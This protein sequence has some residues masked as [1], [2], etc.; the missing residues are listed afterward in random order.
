MRTSRNLPELGRIESTSTPPFEVVLTYQDFHCGLRAKEFF[1]RLV[2]DH[3]SLFRF[4][5]HLWRFD[6]L[7]APELSGQAIAEA[8][9]AD[10]I[11]IAARAQAELPAL[12][13]AWI[14]RWRREP[15]TSGA[16]VALLDGLQ[17]SSA[18]TVCTYLRNVAT[19]SQMRFFCNASPPSEMDIAFPIEVVQ[20]PETT[21]RLE[22]K[23]RF[24]D[25]AAASHWG[26]NE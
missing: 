1:N 6:F 21:A 23:V 10:M 14:E 12:A 9:N 22:N 2:R 26:I 5:C 16:L 20:R 15:R 19:T 11:V 18:S 3:G 17:T 13:K 4:L 7:S 24:R 25:L 8:V